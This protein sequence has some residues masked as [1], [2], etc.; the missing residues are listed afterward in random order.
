MTVRDRLI[1]FIAESIPEVSGEI[2]PDQSLVKSGLFNSLLLFK[3]IIWIE[4]EIGSPLD[5]AEVDIPNQLDNVDD[6]L[7]FISKTGKQQ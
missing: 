6:I 7:A 3:L 5:L 2:K 4:G 1:T